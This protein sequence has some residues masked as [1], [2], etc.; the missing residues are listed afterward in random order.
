MN[1]PVTHN[2]EFKQAISR[3]KSNSLRRQ[4]NVRD[5]LGERIVKLRSKK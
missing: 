1:I 2:N 5:K 3:L 4:L